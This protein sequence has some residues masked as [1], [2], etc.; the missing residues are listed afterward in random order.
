MTQTPHHHLCLEAA[1]AYE[2]D[3]PETRHL[4][5]GP[6][7]AAEIVG[8]L[9]A[10]RDR[11]V[12][13]AVHLD[14]KHRVVG[15]ELLSLGSIDHTFMSPRDVYRGS[16]LANA[17]SVV[18]AHNHPSGDATPSRDDELLTKRLARAGELVGVELLDHLVV[19]HGG[20]W[21]SL[22]RTGHLS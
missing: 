15:T 22:A 19:G 11:E 6:D 2:P 18:L 4:V 21:T 10:N 1:R 16:L 20:T 13:I 7:A 3:A 12:C 17:A 14:T 9:L 5:T 8:P